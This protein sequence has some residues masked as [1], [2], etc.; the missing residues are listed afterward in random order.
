[1]ITEEAVWEELNEIRD[2]AFGE[3]LS[4]VEVGLV[5]GVRVSGRDVH[6]DILMF[7]RG[8]ASVASAASPIRQ[9]LL[10]M[11]GVEAVTVECL[12]EP[13]WTPDRLSQRAREA[14]GFVADDPAEGRMHMYA[15][16]RASADAQPLDERRLPGQRLVLGSARRPVSELPREKFARWWGGWRFYQRFQAEE[17]EGLARTGEP[18]H[19]DVSLSA[20]E[21]RDLRREIRIVDEATAEEIPC[22]ICAVE[23]AGS[24]LNATVVYRAEVDARQTRTYLVLHGNSSPVCWTPLYR[25]DL[26]V[27]G[28]GYALEIENGS[29]VARLSPIMGQLRNLEFQGG[30]RTRLGWEDPSPINIIDAANDPLEKLDIAWHGEDYCIHW[31]PD[32]S[33]QLRYRMTNWPEAPN[34]QVDRGPV[35]TQVRRWGYPV[36]PT[37]PA[38]AQQVVRLDVTYCFYQGLPYFVMES[39]VDV[40]DEADIGVVRNDEWLFRQAFTHAFSMVEGDAIAAG[41]ADQQASFAKN[42][43]LLGFYNENN[44]DA[45]ATLRLA[46]DAAGFPGAYD[47]RHTHIGTTRFGN[48]IWGRGAFHAGGERLAIQSGATVGER[49][50]YLCFRVD[51]EGGLQQAADWYRLLRHPLR[52]TAV[53]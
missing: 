49:N 28:E 12:W 15:G 23:E 48:Q 39:R 30:G 41:P 42:P 47:P 9:Q 25:T 36:C 46:F 52:V 17:T 18:V 14:L 43:A 19:L 27:R 5:Y 32:F 40:E 29:Y 16:G 31:N 35:C 7:N 22:Q 33:N 10:R 13:E 51:D 50:A 26:V 2:P 21:V 53:D 37:H 11:E 6:V 45:F 38:R 34:Y 8:R 1:M 44:R 3:P 4:V 24:T 20:A